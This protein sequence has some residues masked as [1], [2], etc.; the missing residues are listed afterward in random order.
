MFLVPLSNSKTAERHRLRAL[1][2]CPGFAACVLWPLQQQS[3]R[4]ETLQV[5]IVAV[6]QRQQRLGALQVCPVAP[7]A[8]AD[9]A[10]RRQVCL[11]VPAAAEKT[12]E[13][14]AAVC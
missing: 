13:S 12:S 3:Q 4:L 7:A 9:T 1:Q 14:A 10:S 2:A 6:A 5:C 8:A 11:V